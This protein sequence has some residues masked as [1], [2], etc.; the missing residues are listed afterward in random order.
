[1]TTVSND[2][3]GDMPTAPD[4][5]EDK[6]TLA[7]MTALWV[8][9]DGIAERA[10]ELLTPKADGTVST[11]P[12]PTESSASGGSSV[13]RISI[14]FSEK[15]ALILGVVFATAL[16]AYAAA[17]VSSLKDHIDENQH[18]TLYAIEQ[19]ERITQNEIDH[20]REYFAKL[21]R[22]Y[23]MTEMKLDAWGVTA[24]RAG[25]KLPGDFEMGPGGNPDAASFNIPML[26]TGES[27]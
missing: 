25:L 9:I 18:I 17:R 21:E 26:R 22:Q 24:R 6:K 14:T 23:R 4:R 8:K 19:H 10:K 15:G 2:D 13:N 11:K 20:Y 12:V 16:A 7:K 1:M 3:E 5:E 27:K